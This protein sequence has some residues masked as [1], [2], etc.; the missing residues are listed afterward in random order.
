[1]TQFSFKVEPHKN[2]VL[3]TVSRLSDGAVKTF[4]NAGHLMV[5]PMTQ[6]M[7]SVTDVQA[8]EYFPK[9]KKK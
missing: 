2:G 4:F 8:A 3:T 6:F 1:M 7:S 5:E 9:Q